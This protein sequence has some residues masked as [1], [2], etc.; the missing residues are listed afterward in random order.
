MINNND[1]YKNEGFSIFAKYLAPTNT[2]GGRIKIYCE[3]F[4]PV[5]YGSQQDCRI[6]KHA[7]NES[8]SFYVWELVKHYCNE[9][10]LEIKKITWSTFNKGDE[11]VF[12]VQNVQGV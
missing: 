2:K 7:E 9:N 8:G 12:I 11:H 10:D 1:L 6:S 5:V 3:F 4:K